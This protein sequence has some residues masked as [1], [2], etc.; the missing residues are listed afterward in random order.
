MNWKRK[1]WRI[2]LLSLPILIDQALSRAEW[3]LIKKQE[4]EESWER[5]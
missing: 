3:A 4:N 2:F 5:W 1:C